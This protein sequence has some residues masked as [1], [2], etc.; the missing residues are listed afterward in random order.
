MK[1]LQKL[2]ETKILSKKEQQTVKGGWIKECKTNSQ[3]WEGFTCFR[4]I[5]VEGVM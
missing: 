1:K 5:C 3:C 2:A 4:G